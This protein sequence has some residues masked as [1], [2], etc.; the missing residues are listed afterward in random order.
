MRLNKIFAAALLA[1]LWIAC[2]DNSHLNKDHHQQ[3]KILEGGVDGGGGKGVLCG[4]LLA[5]LDLFE[6]R[7]NGHPPV[8]EIK[9]TFL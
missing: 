7:I 8:S 3:D 6:A 9:N 5:T 2:A 1:C 4:S